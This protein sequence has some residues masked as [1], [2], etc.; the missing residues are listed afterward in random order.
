[1]ISREYFVPVNTKPILNGS[2]FSNYS[3]SSGSKSI[4]GYSFIPVQKVNLLRY[5]FIP[6]DNDL[7]FPSHLPVIF[8]ITLLLPWQTT[9]PVQGCSGKMNWN[10]VTTE[11]IQFYKDGTMMNY[12]KQCLLKIYRLTFGVKKAV[13]S[14]FPLRTFNPFP[15][16]KF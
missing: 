6:E 15:N 14:C 5:C 13:N 12:F 4:I 2:N 16:D 3:Y 8:S 10:R 11:N 1:M 7:D 9:N